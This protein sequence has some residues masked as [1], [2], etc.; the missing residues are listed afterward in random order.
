RRSWLDGMVHNYFD[1]SLPVRSVEMQQWGG[2]YWTADAADAL[3]SA[4]CFWY[5]AGDAAASGVRNGRP[6]GR[7]NGMSVRCVRDE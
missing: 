6:M 1:E 7:A 2:Y 3:A 4:F 5:D